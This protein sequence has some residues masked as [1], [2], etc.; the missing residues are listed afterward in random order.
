MSL[1]ITEPANAV[2]NRRYQLADLTVA[3]DQP[4]FAVHVQDGEGHTSSWIISGEL[5][6]ERFDFRPETWVPDAIQAIVTDSDGQIWAITSEDDLI[7][8]TDLGHLD[9]WQTITSHPQLGLRSNWFTRRL[10][11]ISPDAEKIELACC[12]AW[13]HGSLLIGTCD[14]RLYRWD[15]HGTAILEYDDQRSDVLGGI[16]GI[17]ET[18]HAVYAL[19]YAGLIL[20]R[21]AEGTWQLLSGPWPEEANAFVNL[22]AGVEGP[23]GELLAVAAG[24]SVISVSGEI[25]RTIAQVPAE[26]LGI[27]QFQRQWFVSTLDGC[28]ELPGDGDV[29]LI[30]RH[31]LMGKVVDAGSC[32]IA[33]DAEP[34]S[35]DSAEIHVWLRNRSRDSWFRQVVCRP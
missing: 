14:R 26:P 31:I 11:Y 12:L 22:I 25:L 15:S 8:N 10:R 2:A 29:A 19:G 16:N 24:G 9:G 4:W 30:K 33:F 32:L 17:V 21:R 5:N 34:Q 20:R 13:V 3:G 27:T 23:K 6:G 28:Y 35:R 18:A 7:T 1:D